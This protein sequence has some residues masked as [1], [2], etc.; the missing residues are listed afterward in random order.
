LVNSILGVVNSNFLNVYS[1]IPWVKH[2]AILIKYWGKGDSHR[3]IDKHLLS[4]YGIVLMLLHFLIKKKKVNLIYDARNRS[5][6]VPNFIYKR[7]K[8]E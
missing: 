8:N 3:V 1:Q 4:S 5:K 7:N 6:E 2:L